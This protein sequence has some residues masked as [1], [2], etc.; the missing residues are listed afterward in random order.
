MMPDYIYDLAEMLQG[1]D[2]DV[3]VATVYLTA[4]SVWLETRRGSASILCRTS[5]S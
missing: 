5:Q 2:P 3:V 1:F 4:Y